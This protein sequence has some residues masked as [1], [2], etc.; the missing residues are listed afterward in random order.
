MKLKK[1]QRTRDLCIWHDGFSIANHGHLMMSICTDDEYLN[2]FR[3]KVEIQRKVE[4]PVMYLLA[5]CPA[6]DSQLTCSNTRMEDMIDLSNSLT[7]RNDINIYDKRRFFKGDGPA[8][9]H[10]AGQQKGGSFF[11]WFCSFDIVRCTD[12]AYTLNTSMTYF[13][14]CIRKVLATNSATDR[15][16]NFCTKIF[17]NLQKH[18]II[19]ELKA[20]DVKFTCTET[21]RSLQT[22]LEK[23]A[24]DN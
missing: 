18:Q 17:N 16:K 13:R 15:S 5:R 20:S 11:G 19:E 10:E 12:L 3:K 8:C 14:D 6:D 22:K 21:K 7:V 9:Q 2:V 23:E 24:K 4:K 1:L